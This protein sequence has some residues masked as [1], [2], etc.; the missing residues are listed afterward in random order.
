[1]YHMKKDADM[2]GCD[3]STYADIV[4]RSSDKSWNFLKFLL[5]TLRPMQ[6][7]YALIPLLVSFVDI[8][9]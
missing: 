8:S 4:S 5:G 7:V 6:S 9:I 3:I 1:M 2:T